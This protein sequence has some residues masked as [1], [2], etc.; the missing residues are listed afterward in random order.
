MVSRLLPLKPLFFVLF[1]TAVPPLIISHPPPN[2]N[3]MGNPTFNFTVQFI[4]R[5]QENTTVTWQKDNIF[6]PMEQVQTS[7]TSEINGVTIVNFPTIS[8]SDAGLYQVTIKNVIPT[9]SMIATGTY[10]LKVLGKTTFHLRVWYIYI[11]TCTTFQV[12][13]IYT[14][15]FYNYQ[16]EPSVNSHASEHTHSCC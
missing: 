14:I 12:L 13:L 4:S 15:A 5:F 8:R 2:T 10:Q 16:Y 7:Y 11:Y 9:T 6:L 1:F 3:I